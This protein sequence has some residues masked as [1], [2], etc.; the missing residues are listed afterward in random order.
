MSSYTS[1]FLA[2]RFAHGL[3]D[4]KI[5]VLPRL[6]ELLAIWS[7]RLEGRAELARLTE[8]ELRDIGISRSDVWAETRKPFWRA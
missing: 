1:P 3:A 2:P 4:R 7:R 8:R 5:G 6:G